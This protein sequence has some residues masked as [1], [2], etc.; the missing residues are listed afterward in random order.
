MIQIDGYIGNDPEMRTAARLLMEKRYA[1]IAGMQQKLYFERDDGAEPAG[2]G[3][4][5]AG[6]QG[7]R[8]T[9]TTA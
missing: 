2:A 4:L 3:D 7:R 8:A 6:P 9:P 5:H 1:N